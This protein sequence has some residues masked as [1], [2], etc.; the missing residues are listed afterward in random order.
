[1][2]CISKRSSSIFFLNRGLF[3]L[4]NGCD[5]MATMKKY[6]YILFLFI[7]VSILSAKCSE[8]PQAKKDKYASNMH[9]AFILQSMGK[10]TAASAQFQ[11][12]YE[13]AKKAGENSLKLKAVEQLF[14]WYRMYGSCLNLFS[15]KPTGHD[16]IIG[17]YKPMN[18]RVP[19]ESE[20]G[21]TPE[22]AAQIR[23][24]MFGVA[25]IIS[26]IFC[27]TIS[28]GF[29]SAIGWTI[30]SDGVG[31]IYSSLNNVWAQHQA[32]ISLKNW[33]QTTLKAAN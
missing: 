19:F 27:V 12:A 7:N 5:W 15:N 2:R 1:M 21:K 30:T 14:V 9:Y 26:G 11:S 25:E 29:G 8:V 24:F 28:S 20:W 18:T 16:R 22:Q 4:H 33:E 23:E 17:E 31:R 6:F 13:E 10:S 32:M 3:D